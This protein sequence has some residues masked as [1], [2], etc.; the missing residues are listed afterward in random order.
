MKRIRCQ[1]CGQEIVLKDGSKSLAYE[2]EMHVI[3]RHY[4]TNVSVSVPVVAGWMMK[5]EVFEVVQGNSGNR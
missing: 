1:L 5:D 3:E 4:P 2:V